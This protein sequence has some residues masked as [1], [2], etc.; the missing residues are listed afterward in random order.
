MDES[1]LGFFDCEPL[2][3]ALAQVD[4]EIDRLQQMRGDL[5]SLIERYRARTTVNR[6]S[7]EPAPPL[8]RK[9]QPMRGRSR[10]KWT[11]F[12]REFLA[13]RTGQEFRVSDIID[14]YL[15]E[16]VGRKP[17]T[18]SERMTLASTCARLLNVGAI[19]GRMHD[20]VCYYSALP[21]ETT[22]SPLSFGA[23]SDVLDAPGGEGS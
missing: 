23:G 1:S 21:K 6:L 19:A 13:T 2:E 7:Q 20:H 17:F 12:V 4:G 15:R 10:L 9:K 5:L 11:R 18:R 16:G 14:N 22:D 8:P 3:Q